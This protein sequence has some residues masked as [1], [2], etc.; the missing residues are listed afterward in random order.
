MGIYIGINPA[1]REDVERILHCLEEKYVEC[2]NCFEKRLAEVENKCSACFID[3]RMFDN[4][5]V[6]LRSGG[7]IGL[8]YWFKMS[9]FTIINPKNIKLKEDLG[10]IGAHVF[11]DEEQAMNV[12][13]GISEGIRNAEREVR[14][15]E[16]VEV[17]NIVRETLRN[18]IK[19]DINKMLLLNT[20]EINNLKKRL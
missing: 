16:T 10:N 13:G 20:K 14:G 19:D 6:D 8:S 12:L 3:L 5:K 7:L 18:Y 1:K 11:D 17:R 9:I 15:R 4:S 2:Y